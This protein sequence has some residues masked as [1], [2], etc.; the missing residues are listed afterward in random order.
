VFRPTLAVS[1]LLAVALVLGRPLARDGHGAGAAEPESAPT[2]RELVVGVYDKP[3]FSMRSPDGDWTGLAV[4]LWREIALR[5]QLRFRFEP[6]ALDRLL[7]AVQEKQVDVAVGPLTITAERQRAMEF[8][9]PFL[10]VAFGIASR[11][12]ST[13]SWLRA[14]VSVFSSRILWTSLALLATMVAFGVVVWLV[15]RGRNPEH[16]GGPAGHGIGEGVW[17]SASTMSTVGYGDRT[18]VTLAGRLVGIVW[19]FV[20]IVLVSMFT[21]LVTSSLTVHNLDPVIRTFADLTRVRVGAVD[22]SVGAEFLAE[23]GVPFRRYQ[24]VEAGVRDVADRAIDAFVD[25]EPVLKYLAAAHAGEVAVV[26]HPRDRGFVAFA[27]PLD[28]PLRH[29]IDVDLL[30]VVHGAPWREEVRSYLGR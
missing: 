18:P 27:L 8:T 12:S 25:E 22:E 4:D 13:G 10:N 11:P 16:F 3:P 5:E 29:A 24:D 1:V 14:T 23:R 2:S 30:E 6:F 15:E 19:M 26:P 28:S 20:S 21:A 7:Q 9:S 17:W